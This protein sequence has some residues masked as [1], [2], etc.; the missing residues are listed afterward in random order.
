MPREIAVPLG[1]RVS[2]R[3]FTVQAKL[4]T[5]CTVCVDTGVDEDGERVVVLSARDNLSSNSVIR[6]L[7]ASSSKGLRSVPVLGALTDELEGMLGMLLD[8]GSPMYGWMGVKGAVAGLL[9]GTPV[10]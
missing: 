2:W 8:V 5:V 7:I 9:S 4:L 6:A 1:I 10:S 3:T